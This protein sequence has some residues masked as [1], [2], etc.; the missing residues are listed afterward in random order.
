MVFLV[1]MYG[2]KSW[3]IKKAEHQRIDAFKLWCWR[4]LFESPLDSKEIKP[5]N[6]KGNQTW[7]FIGRTDAEAPILWPP[8]AKNCE[9]TLMLEKIENR[10]RGGRQ[11]MRWLDGIT[12]KMDMS[13]SRLQDLVMDREAWHTEVRGVKK[14]RTRLSDWTELNWIQLIIHQVLSMVQP[15][16]QL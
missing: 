3:T 5:I 4:R 11:R 16:S 12:N 6:P 7:K 13:L 14:S 10:R 8:D 1:V 9:K 2:C 15:L